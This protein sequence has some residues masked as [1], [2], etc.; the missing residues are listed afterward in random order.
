M[1]DNKDIKEKEIFYNIAGKVA[2]WMCLGSAENNGLVISGSVGIG[3]SAMLTAIVMFLNH[4]VEEKPNEYNKYAYQKVMVTANNLA[5]QCLNS[6]SSWE[7]VTTTK[8]ILLID[9]VGCEPTEVKE[10]GN[11][12][13][14]FTECLE[15]RYNRKIYTILTT[16]FTKR[17]EWKEK[18]GDRVADRIK[19]FTHISYAT[20]SYR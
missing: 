14:P 10:Y 16:N 3:K 2:K 12:F 18:Y 4:R 1:K 13:L 5:D 19:S 8:K 11:R 20:K 15:Q 6:E 7:M 17:D 9:D